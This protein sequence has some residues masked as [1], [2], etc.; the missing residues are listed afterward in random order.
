MD[1]SQ[2]SE[3]DVVGISDR[4]KELS[5]LNVEGFVLDL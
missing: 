1:S 3:I 5:L 2:R 4:L